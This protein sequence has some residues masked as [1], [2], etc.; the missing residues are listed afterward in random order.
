MKAL[1]VRR[2]NHVY[3][4]K[5]EEHFCSLLLGVILAFHLYDARMKHLKLI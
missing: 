3:A 4:T 2:E 5:M 1:T